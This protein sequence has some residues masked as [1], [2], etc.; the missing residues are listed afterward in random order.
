MKALK[1]VVIGMGLLILLGLAVVVATLASRV[2]DDSERSAGKGE[3]REVALGVSAACEVAGL[4]E[5]D[6]IV[7]LHLDGPAEAD[8]P[9][10]LLLDPGSGEVRRV[11]RTGRGARGDDPGTGETAPADP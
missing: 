8:C 3:R 10:V 4:A 6:D 11:L 5:A 9:A 7:A 1:A 2:S